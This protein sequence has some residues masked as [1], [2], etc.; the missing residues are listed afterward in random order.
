MLN[1]DQLQQVA[2]AIRNAESFTS[3]EIRVCVAKRC[4]GEPLQAAA[5]KFA[6]LKMD[7]TQLRNAVLIYV[8]P[9]DHK[10]AIFGD[11]GICEAAAGGFWDNALGEMLHCFKN[12]MIAEGICRGVDKVGELIK[13]RY[14]VSENDV[15]ELSDDVILEE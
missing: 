15:N 6:Q 12:E 14:P 8:C 1:S 2:Q 4:K 7:A 9:A 13:A 10:A 5:A 11:T 3:G